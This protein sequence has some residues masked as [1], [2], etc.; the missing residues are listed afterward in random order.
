MPTSARRHRSDHRPEAG[1]A[2][3][4]RL[5]LPLLLLS[6]LSLLPSL[7]LAPARAV[8]AQQ[9]PTRAARVRAARDTMPR[10]ETASAHATAAAA[11]AAAG[12]KVDYIPAVR[13][14]EARRRA[15]RARTQ[16]APVHVAADEET[17]YLIVV[18]TDTSE[19]EQHARWDDLV[20]V[21]S[22]H[23]V[24]RF[25]ARSAGR[26]RIAAGEYR[27]GQLV[28]A[29]ELHLG[30]GDVARVPAGVPHAFWPEAAGVAGAVAPFE[31][32]I[33]KIRRGDRPLTPP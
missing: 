14:A 18:R 23:G 8:D 5:P 22:G 7:F 6:L 13:F 10:F 11:R 29:H 15:A 27:G 19:V 25:G 26:R 30:P 2:L 21:E 17:S 24:V 12:R 1:A 32:R 31:Y 28:E 33:V 3:R 9:A 4:S 16:G 20:L